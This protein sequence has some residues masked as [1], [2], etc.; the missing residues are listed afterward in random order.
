PQLFD[1]FSQA[2]TSATRSH[3]GLGLGLFLVR[4]LV[5]LHAGRVTAESRGRG[6]GTTFT[7]HFPLRV[8]SHKYAAVAP[9]EDGG[10]GALPLPSLEGR[11]ILLIDDQEEARESLSVVLSSAGA[12]VF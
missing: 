2:D 11:R 1:R 7:V 12:H 6:F 9:Y 4:H 8:R 5:E 10:D 3:N